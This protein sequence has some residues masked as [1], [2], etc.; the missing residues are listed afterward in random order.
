MEVSTAVRKY[1]M[2]L[3]ITCGLL[4]SACL[5]NANTINIYNGSDLVGTL[6]S[7]TT[8]DDILGYTA[9]GVTSTT[10]A[11]LFEV[12]PSDPPDEEAAFDIMA[13]IDVGTAIQVPGFGCEDDC[14]VS[15]ATT[16]FKLK[17]GKLSA[18]FQNTT[19]FILALTYEQVGT[20]GGLSHTT[21]FGEFLDPPQSTGEVP[22]PAG[23]VLLI[24]ALGG[25][26]VLRRFRKVGVAA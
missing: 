25:L 11:Q 23:I 12:I 21:L 26:G 14:A 22:L 19:G 5:A 7:G 2:G 9:A 6:S 13:G 24:S 4:M 10:E 18:F 16:Y 3:A 8:N 20:A 15:A 17:L 1:T